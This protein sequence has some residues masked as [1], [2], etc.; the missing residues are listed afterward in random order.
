MERQVNPILR[1]GDWRVNPAAGEIS[2]NGETAR[3][4]ARTMRLL[5]YL[6]QRPGQ[7]VSIEELLDEVWSGVV[8]SQD[9]VY[10]AVASLRRLLGDD[11]KQPTYI[12]TV[13]RLGYRL[14]A[15]VSPWTDDPGSQS[16]SASTTANTFADSSPVPPATSALPA[17][18]GTQT[19]PNSRFKSLA[20][21]SG[22]GVICLVLGLAFLLHDR[23]GK[24]NR[25]AQA[26]SAT[27]PQ[28]SIAV[29][30]FVDE[31]AGM[32]EEE[33]ADG[34]SEEI[35]DKLS[36]IPGCRVPAAT[37]SFYY[38][39]KQI[40]VAEIGRALGV[41]YVLDGSTRK[42]GGNV[43]I[44]ARLVRAENGYV[45]WSETYDRPFGDRV[46]LQDEVADKI[47]KALRASIDAV[48]TTGTGSP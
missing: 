18:G 24:T 32:T 12:A 25:T 4:E 44:A 46:A 15:P 20:V 5:V 27:G 7:V 47:T 38:K 23:G 16:S 34:V 22:A 1:I 30:S 17:V 45:I 36:K 35:I 28:K 43:R 26:S 9:S 2:R 42:S 10:Q 40:P 14:L 29:L 3:L 13:P 33:F 8:V 37:A 6:A 19:T 31:T 39:N 48:P 41:I 21:W 11:P